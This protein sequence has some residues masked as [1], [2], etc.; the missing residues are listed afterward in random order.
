[1]LPSIKAHLC[2]DKILT[3]GTYYKNL[4][5]N[6][7]KKV[8]VQVVGSNKINLNISKYSKENFVFARSYLSECEILF[9]LKLK[10]SKI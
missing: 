4:L 7:F 1:M 8:E 9:K 3:T 2:P 6:L 10:Y 5:K